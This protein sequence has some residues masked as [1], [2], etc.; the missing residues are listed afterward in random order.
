MKFKLLLPVCLVL[1]SLSCKKEESTKVAQQFYV[2]PGERFFP[3]GIAYNPKTGIFYTGSTV[4][5][6]I[7]QVDVQ[8]GESSL[9][10]PGAKQGRSFCTGMKLDEKGRLWVCG[11]STGTIQVLGKD[12][13]LLKSWDVKTLYGAGFINDCIISNGYIYF[14]DSN[15]KKI[16]RAS[17]TESQ[18][19]NLEEWLSFTEQQIPYGVGTAANGIEVTPDGKTLIIVV[20]NSG[21]LYKVDI[22]TKAIKEIALNAFLNSGDGLLL[23]GKILYV[24]PNATG[25]IFPLI[26]NSDYSVA[27]I[28]GGFGE[29]LIGNTTLAKA[30]KYLLVVNGQ[31]SRRAGVIPPA[32]PFKV[33]RVQIP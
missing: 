22:A 28:G 11:G 17:V 9:F 23:E 32:L 29:N 4:S 25:K 18:P 26:L 10:S 13:S 20:S 16:Y 2:I 21:R 3:E 8:T 5:G 33:S 6:D 12:G 1:F 15:V 30:G 14:T 7:L 31:L 19:A 27:V 24:S